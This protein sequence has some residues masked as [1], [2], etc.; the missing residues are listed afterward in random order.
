MN[1][2]ELLKALEILPPEADIFAVDKAGNRFIT[3]S[4]SAVNIVLPGIKEIAHIN[5]PAAFIEIST[6]GN[7]SRAKELAFWLDK[8][9]KEAAAL[10]E[11]EEALMFSATEKP[12][13]MRFTAYRDTANKIAELCRYLIETNGV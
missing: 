7:T 8:Y 1:K 2:Y 9:S 6:P 5:N 4:A 12:A 10:P 13:Y 11:I 3:Q